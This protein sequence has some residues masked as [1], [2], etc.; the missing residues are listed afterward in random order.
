MLS[1][2]HLLL[3]PVLGLTMRI[4]ESYQLGPPFWQGLPSGASDMVLNSHEV[5]HK[6]I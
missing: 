1:F 5:S 2:F 3:L 6:Y 4:H